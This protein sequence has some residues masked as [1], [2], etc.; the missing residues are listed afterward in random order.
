[1]KDLSTKITL[2]I[3]LIGIWGLFGFRIYQRYQP[4]N[5]NLDYSANLPTQTQSNAKQKEFKFGLELDYRDPFLGESL[6][7]KEQYQPSKPQRRSIRTTPIKETPKK[8]EKPQKLKSVKFPEVEYK[9][10]IRLKS[11]RSVALVKVEGQ[12]INWGLGEQLSEMNL[13]RI[14]E[15]SIQIKLQH[16]EKLILKKKE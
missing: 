5:D 9:G 11:G 12:M 10:N 13:L 8:Q 4:T 3:A 1:M 14:Y 7:R 6:A 15:D 16:E 2:G